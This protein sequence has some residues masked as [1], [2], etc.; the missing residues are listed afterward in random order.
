MSKM[1]EIPM[2]VRCGHLKGVD[3]FTPVT[4]VKNIMEN[5]QDCFYL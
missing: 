4:R 1:D 2:Y 5:I 3:Y